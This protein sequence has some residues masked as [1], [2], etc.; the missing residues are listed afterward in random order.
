M[1]PSFRIFAPLA[2]VLSFVALN[3]ARAQATATIC[4]DG[5]TSSASGRGACSGHGGVNKKATSKEKSVVKEQVKAAKA[6]AKENPRGHGR[7]HMRRW[8]NIDGHWPRCV[9]WSRR[10]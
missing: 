9:L 2:L 1:R 3:S 7:G 6:A 5:S 4:K 8:I 10:S